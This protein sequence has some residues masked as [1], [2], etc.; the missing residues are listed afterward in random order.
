MK[1]MAGH[2]L[3]KRERRE[4]CEG[5]WCEKP[6]ESNYLE[7]LGVYGSMIYIAFLK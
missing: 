5:F 2:I 7:N 4:M 6:K 1:I 3:H